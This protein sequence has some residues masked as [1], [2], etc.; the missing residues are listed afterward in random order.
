MKNIELKWE[1]DESGEQTF[2]VYEDGKKTG[3]YWPDGQYISVDTDDANEFF[4]KIFKSLNVKGTKDIHGGRGKV[5]NYILTYNGSLKLAKAI[6]NFS[7][8]KESH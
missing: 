4:Q 3:W 1:K 5:M 7:N 6:V 2:I 8:G